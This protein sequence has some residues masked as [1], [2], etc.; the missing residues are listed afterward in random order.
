MQASMDVLMHAIQ[1][2]N[3]SKSQRSCARRVDVMPT[4]SEL[5]THVTL[6]SLPEIKMQGFLPGSLAGRGVPKRHSTAL[7]PLPINQPAGHT[8][9]AAGCSPAARDSAL[10]LFCGF[11]SRK[12]FA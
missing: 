5:P 4:E 2:W 10:L 11:L 8:L 9:Q 1:T 7:K 6:L 12:S 3:H